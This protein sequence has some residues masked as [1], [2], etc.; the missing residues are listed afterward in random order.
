MTT[1][2][3]ECKFKVGNLVYPKPRNNYI[4][5]SDAFI[6]SHTREQYFNGGHGTWRVEIIYTFCQPSGRPD[7]LESLFKIFGRGR[8][9]KHLILVGLKALVVRTD[10]P[11]TSGWGVSPGHVSFWVSP[12]VLE[13][14]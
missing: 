8:T 2:V 7:W 10:A 6:W 1:T 5:V 14:L 4:D 3:T 11:D 13:T 12:D 9:Y